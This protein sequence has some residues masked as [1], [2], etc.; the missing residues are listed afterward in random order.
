[1]WRHGL[2]LF[3]AALAAAC[4][5]TA[6]RALSS[7]VPPPSDLPYYALAGVALLLILAAATLE[8]GA[9]RAVLWA[10]GAQLGL[11][12]AVL[13]LRFHDEAPA[14][15]ADL[16]GHALAAPALAL[17]GFVVGFADPWGGI[18]IVTGM[19]AGALAAHVAWMLLTADA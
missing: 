12:G 4:A 17:L 15:L 19:G 7:P 8:W 6:W 10:W 3:A 1:M 5:A 9:R 2:A 18:A 16:V 13:V 11:D 14:D